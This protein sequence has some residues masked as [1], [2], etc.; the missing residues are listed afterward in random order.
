[1]LR[2]N[3]TLHSGVIPINNSYISPGRNVSSSAVIT[4]N[5]LFYAPI[6]ISTYCRIIEMGVDVTSIATFAQKMVIGI[7]EFDILT[8][9][10]STLI[11]QTSEIDLGTV[12]VGLKSQPIALDLDPGVYYIVSHCEDGSVRATLRT[13]SAVDYATYP[14][15]AATGTSNVIGR[16]VVSAYS[17]TLPNPAPPSTT[18][19]TGTMVNTKLKVQAR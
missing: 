16:S 15:A 11:G 10:P 3:K 9:D 19:I 13:F 4:G 14:L 7:Y 2:F 18:N 6:R 5:T 1:M 17:A 8:G 12:G